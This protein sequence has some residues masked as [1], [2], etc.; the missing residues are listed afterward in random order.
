M[1]YLIRKTG[2]G[3]SM[4]WLGMCT[5]LRGINVCMV[6]LLGLGSAQAPNSRRHGDNIEAYHIDEFKSSLSFKKLANYLL[7]IP[8][9]QKR[10]IILYISPQMLVPGTKWHDVIH[11]LSVKGTISSFCIDEVHAAVE[12]SQS[13]RPA[14][15]HA[16]HAIQGLIQ[17]S[18]NLRPNKTIPLLVMSATFRLPEQRA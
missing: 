13:F 16:V 2:E 18:R 14:F 10:S 7:N 5:I 1:I 4:V 3:K 8:V 17:Q 15:G 11:K 6:P 12:N 9:G